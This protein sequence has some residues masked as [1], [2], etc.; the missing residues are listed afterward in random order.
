M[1]RIN[2]EDS[3]FRD[4]RFVNL[5]IALGSR[6]AAIGAIIEAWMLAQEFVTPNNPS[7]QIP[8]DQ[9][10]L[11]GMADEVVG[12]GLARR[13]E[14]G[15]IEIAGARE[16]FAWLVQR[17]GAGSKVT[18]KKLQQLQ[19]ARQ[20]RADKLSKNTERNLNGS[21]RE[22]NGTEP[23]TLTTFSYSYSSS[24]SDSCSSLV[25]QDDK[26]PGLNG[27]ERTLNET[28]RKEK[29]PKADDPDAGLRK[30]TWLAYA[31]AYQLRWN[32]EPKRNATVNATIK[33]LVARVGEDAPAL[34]RFFLTHNDGYY[35]KACH[36][37]T[38]CLKDH[39]G[40]MTQM[41]RGQQ[42]TN[43]DVRQLEKAQQQHAVLKDVA[44]G[45]F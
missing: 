15:T 41:Q 31:D 30:E 26:S 5:C 1:P 33:N 40:L 38:A 13:T 39:V 18:D 37:I 24:S 17:Q 9:W 43:A 19:D 42:I 27:T 32:V 4:V 22:L 25:S 29:K 11:R 20:K 45:G 16:H 7:G 6:R 21:E 44:K 35:I 34:V 14:D 36:P 28:E 12:V 10:T 2:L 8:N 23:L 3:L